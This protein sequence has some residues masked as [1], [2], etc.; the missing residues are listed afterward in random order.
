V[1]RNAILRFKFT[2]AERNLVELSFFAHLIA[3]LLPAFWL[4][5]KLRL[6]V[7]LQIGLALLVFEASVIAGAGLLSATH[8]LNNLFAYRL[9]TTSLSF[10]TTAAIWWFARNDIAHFKHADA[11]NLNSD[12]PVSLLWSKAPAAFLAMFALAMLVLTLNSYPS[13]EDSLTIKLPKIVFAI[14]ANS[15]LPTDLTDDGRM[16][17]SPVYPALVQLFMIVSGQNGHALLV[18]G[19]VNWAICGFSVFQICRNI[20]ASRFASWTTLAFLLLSPVL[21]AQGSSEGDDIIAATPAVVALMFL[22]S[23][24]NTSSRLFAALSGF[25]LGVSVAMKFLPLLYF[26]V[27]PI[28]AIAALFQYSTAQIQSWGKPRLAGAMAFTAAFATALLPHLIVNWAAFGNPFYVSP[29]VAATRNSPFDIACGLRSLIGYVEQISISDYAHLFQSPTPDFILRALFKPIDIVGRHIPIVRSYIPAVPDHVTL[30]AKVEGFENRLSSMFPF[31]PTA[32]CSAYG[33]PFKLTS[34]YVTDVTTWFGVFGPLLLASSL[35]VLFLKRFSL[36]VRSLGL[37]FIVWAIMFAF[38]QKYLSEIGRYWSMAVILGSPVVAIMADALLRNGSHRIAYRSV[39]MGI[40]FLTAALG[41]TVLIDNAHRPYRGL[42]ATPS[43][44]TSGFSPEF[45]A[46]MDN[47]TSV[48]VHTAYG[49]DTYDYYKLLQEGAK[50][51]NK[52][53][54]LTH[55]TNV[56]IVRP[57]G[58]MNNPYSD[59]RMPVRMKQPFAGGFRYFGNVRPQPGNLYNLGFANNTPGTSGAEGNILLF[60]VEG[61]GKKDEFIVGAVRPIESPE[62]LKT[63]RYRVGWRESSGQTNMSE[64]WSAGGISQVFKIPE[65]AA[66]IIVEAVFDGTNNVG[67]SGWPVQEFDP[68]LLATLK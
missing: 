60:D 43:R 57:S 21:I 19:F 13:V 12:R 52:S 11:I 27:V 20:G 40:G 61:V 67:S 31:T 44:Y 3:I 16:Y 55:A 8:L 45:R 47:A 38:S 39:I 35:V 64:E 68:T 2:L 29:S 62:I 25:G 32:A 37:A 5:H 42:F 58:L 15:I 17:I 34:L 22:S 49:I 46:M 28:I 14:E 53:T 50:L 26:P 9:T 63:I 66:S 36:F 30:V 24:L 23:W 18:F 59:P 6:S 54:I 4:G 65:H 10:L 56:V 51:T 7:P 48:N 1:H 41:V 33:R